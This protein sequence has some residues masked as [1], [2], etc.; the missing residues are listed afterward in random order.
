[1]LSYRNLQLKIEQTFMEVWIWCK[2][3]KTMNGDEN[4]YRVISNYSLSQSDKHKNIYVSV[5][6][7]SKQRK[8]KQFWLTLNP[9]SIHGLLTFLIEI[10][11]PCRS[12]AWC[13]DGLAF[14]NA[15]ANLNVDVGEHF[16]IKPS[17]KQTTIKCCPFVI[18]YI[19]K[20]CRWN[21]H[22]QLHETNTCTSILNSKCK[23]CLVDHE[24]TW[25]YSIRLL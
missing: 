6:L 25:Y 7:E 3:G 4:G 5:V 8:D 11:S 23:Y 18:R 2:R 16:R 12:K 19:E 14:N 20:W 17:S 1:M 24:Q 21:M 10:N 9:K 13:R 15:V 22:T